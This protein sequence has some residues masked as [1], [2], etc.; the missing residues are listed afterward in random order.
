MTSSGT[1]TAEE[2]KEQQQQA[3]TK[4][5]VPWRK[6]FAEMAI[7]SRAATELILQEAQVQPGMQVLDLASGPGDPAL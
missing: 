3:W 7:Q 6:W 4:S 5:A 2:F 1:P